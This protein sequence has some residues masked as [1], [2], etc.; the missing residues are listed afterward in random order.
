MLIPQELQLSLFSRFVPL[1]RFI[2]KI[3]YNFKL[4]EL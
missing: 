3:N 1:K 4:N 2:G